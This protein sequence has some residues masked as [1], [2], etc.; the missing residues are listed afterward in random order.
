MTNCAP[1]SLA[2]LV[3]LLMAGPTLTE[4]DELPPGGGRLGQPTWEALRLC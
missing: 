4:S 3:S 2:P 1:T